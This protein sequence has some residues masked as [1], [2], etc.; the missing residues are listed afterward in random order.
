MTLSDYDYNLPEERIAQHPA[1]ERD[2]SR[3]MVLK[4]QERL[5]GHARF[6]DL[7]DF[8]RPG[9][10]LVVNETRVFPARLKGFRP[11]SGGAV[12]L[13]LLR[14][15][16]E[17]WEA[18]VRPGRRMRVGVKVAFPETDLTAVVEAVC[19]SGYRLF[20]FE[21]SEPLED[22]LE[23]RGQVPL[24]PYIR[25]EDGAEDRDRYQTVYA[26]T[27]GAVAAPTAGL[28]FTPGLL[29]RVQALGVTVVPVLLHV[30]PGTFKPVAVEDPAQHEM[31]AEFFE[32]GAEAAGVIN[33]C[34]EQGGRVVAVGS[35]SVRT[36]ES[37]AVLV[38]DRWVLR[39]QSGWTRLFIYPPYSFRSVDALITNFHLPRS[40]LL[41]LV[42]TFADRAFVLEAYRQAVRQGYRFYSYGD[43]MFIE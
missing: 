18:M 29:D 33:R 23:R 7:T 34:R 31:E 39:P 36:L 6:R 16:G 3:L 22:L 40:T 24:P 42:S 11:E 19:P 41:M 20:R 8:L 10:C 1:A 25:R 26:R 13:L 32:V 5:I 12:E 37:A 4:R 15:E 30:G 21:G 27:A 43:A 9:D 14:R 2:G 35:T 38:G 17:L 28:H